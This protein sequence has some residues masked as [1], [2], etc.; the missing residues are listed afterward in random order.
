MQASD[1]RAALSEIGISQAAFADLAGVNP[2]TVRRWVDQ[3]R[4]EPLSRYARMVIEQ[5]LKTA[6][7]A[8]PDRIPR[9][10]QE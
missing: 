3:R 7:R 8:S 1:L 10:G 6:H 9:R 5:T 4:Q 2:R